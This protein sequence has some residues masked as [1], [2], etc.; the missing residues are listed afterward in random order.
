M[1]R[2]TL[3]PEQFG[4]LQ[5]VRVL[6]TGS[7]IAQPFAA[8][9]AAQ[10][11]AEV[12]QVEN[13]HV[14]DTWRTIGL[15]LPRK[16][17]TGNVSTSWLAE[18]RNE[19][20]VT[21]DMSTP[22]GREI[23][24]KLA[25]RADIWMESSKPGTYP[26]WGLD[27]ATVL[28]R[29]PRLVVCHVSGYGQDGDANTLGRAS[30]DMIGQAFGGSMYQTG[31]PDPMPPTRAAPWTADYITALFCLSSSLAGYIH[32]KETGVGQ[33]IDLAQ[34]EAILAVLAGTMV[35]Y[36]HLGAVRERSGNK[37]PA[38]QPYDVFTA[39]DG[40]VVIA[41]PAQTIFEKACT[42]IGLDP[43]D[44]HWADARTAIN[45]VNGMEFDALFRGWVEE[46]TMAELVET[47][48]A[49]G[50]PCSAIL[51][52]KLAAEDPHYQ[53]RNVHIEW[54]DEQ[55]GTVKGTA[56]VPRFSATPSKIWRGTTGP[57]AD[58][59]RIFGELLG[60]TAEQLS[61]MKARTII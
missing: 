12:I 28:A 56:P 26:K 44:E 45:E 23:F 61:Q 42:I 49:A 30:Y 20:N 53:A 43:K 2:E 55:V 32:A 25:E 58:N 29:N 33:V 15:S 13:P 18:R 57:G 34:F 4:A 40:A 22:E 46:R 7:V 17:G 27:D 35:E 24:L 51:S 6:S 59:E 9:L 1:P 10:M 8:V 37:S 52:S 3:V 54:D 16:D 21:L 38:F 36:F 5:G 39:K 19:F 11:G 47:L 14:D 31:F 48:N 41:A 60:Y 50:V